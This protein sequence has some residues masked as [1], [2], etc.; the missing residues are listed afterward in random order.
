MKY[1]N[2]AEREAYN[3]GLKVAAK[4]VRASKAP[5]TVE[6]YLKSRNEWLEHVAEGIEGEHDA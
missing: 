2:D 1:E 6:G 4:W 3:Q 5:K